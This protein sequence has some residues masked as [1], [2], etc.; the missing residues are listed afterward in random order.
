MPRLRVIVLAQE[1]NNSLTYNVIYWADVPSA[2]QTFYANASATSVWPGAT[3]T[4]IQNL[5]NGSVVEQGQTLAFQP[6]TGLA[7]IETILQREWQ[8]YQTYIT[9]FNP[10][11]H[12]GSTWDGTTWTI[13]SN[14]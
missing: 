9:N 7:Q 5:Q 3:A 4:D 11:V 12:Y 14:P 13:T 8:N 1:A 2:R 6:G 10:W